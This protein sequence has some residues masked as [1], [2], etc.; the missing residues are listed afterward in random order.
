MTIHITL[1]EID[2]LYKRLIQRAKNDKIE[3][4]DIETDYYWIISSDEWDDFSFSPDPCVGSLAED[5]NSLQ[6]ILTTDRI[7]TYLDYDRL[8]SIVRALSEKI[9]PSKKQSVED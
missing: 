8:A 2:L 5:W 6:E 7:V 3:F 4:V 1:D 9:A